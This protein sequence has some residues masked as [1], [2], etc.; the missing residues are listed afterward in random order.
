MKNFVKKLVL[1]LPLLLLQFTCEDRF[2]GESRYVFTTK[3]VDGNN[4]PIPNILVESQNS[5]YSE[6][7]NDNVFAL[8]YSD[9]NG[10]VKLV[11]P[12]PSS[13]RVT[14]NINDNRY[15]ILNLNR[16]NF[17]N[18]A[19]NEENV[20]FYAIED[21]INL[22]ITITNS[23]P[24]NYISKLNFAGNVERFVKD[25]E[26]DYYETYREFRAT[27][28]QTITIEYEVTRVNN[29]NLITTNYSDIITIADTDYS[30]QINL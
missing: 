26:I 2:D 22:N 30:H 1:L 8:T 10:N 29:G 12:F 21:L 13:R 24:N 9:N 20:K 18:Y 4:N 25:Y 28:N 5:N 3:I 19:L 16:S 14:I 17:T 27:K 15:K 23:N 11:F 6:I 7:E